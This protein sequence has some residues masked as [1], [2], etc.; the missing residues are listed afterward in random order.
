MR[1]SEEDDFMVEEPLKGR[2]RRSIQTIHD[3]RKRHE[4]W[5]VFRQKQNQVITKRARDKRK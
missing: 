1:K 5:R 3:N 2:R 4:Q